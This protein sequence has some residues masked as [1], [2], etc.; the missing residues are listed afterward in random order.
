MYLKKRTEKNEQWKR[1]LYFVNPQ[2]EIIITNENP[3]APKSLRF[4]YKNGFIYYIN[5]FNGKKRLC[6]PKSLKK[7]KFIHDE[8]NHGCS[9]KIYKKTHFNLHAKIQ[10]A[11]LT[12]YRKLS[13]LSIKSN[14]R[15]F[16][17]RINATNRNTN[18]FLSH[19]KNKI[20]FKLVNQRHW[21]K[22]IIYKFRNRV[23]LSRAKIYKTFP[24]GRTFFDYYY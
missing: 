8:Q 15:T 14:E 19:T 24:N 16:F 18:H 3:P 11:F 4:R 22:S 9:N 20:Y 1:I 2:N 7:F 13:G 10:A 23:F 12:M 17:I 6:I 21:I 5:E